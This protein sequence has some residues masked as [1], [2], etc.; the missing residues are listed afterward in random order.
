[1]Q[2]IVFYNGSPGSRAHPQ[3]SCAHSIIGQE[4]A[5][6]PVR[7]NSARFHDESAICDGERSLGILLYEQHGQAFPPQCLQGVQDLLDQDG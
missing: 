7:S 2:I 1:L 4:I 3:V 6:A 5:G